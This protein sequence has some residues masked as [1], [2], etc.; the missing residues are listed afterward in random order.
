MTSVPLIRTQ[1]ILE[2]NEDFIAAIAEN[3]QLGRLDDS[4][5]LYSVLF[6]NL[7]SLSLEFDNYPV[8]E[9]TEQTE[10]IL[11]K[12]PDQLM[13]KDPLDDLRPPEDIYVPPKPIIPPC[14]D[15]EKFKVH[16][17]IYIGYIYL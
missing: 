3:I 9:M 17:N 15:C 14:T 5:K 8:D 4:L 2:Q 1:Q 16:E 11:S 10:V 6:D 12:F 7:V 13:R